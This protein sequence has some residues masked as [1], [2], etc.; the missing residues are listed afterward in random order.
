MKE[1]RISSTSAIKT[2][3][4]QIF[5]YL[6]EA[7]VKNE[8]AANERIY[9]KENLINEGRNLSWYQ[10]EIILDLLEAKLIK[11]V[12]LLAPKIIQHYTLTDE[13]VVIA[14]KLEKEKL[15]K[16]ENKKTEPSLDIIPAI[17]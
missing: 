1:N 16:E 15:E 2:L 6:K 12:D 4:D 17:S 3:K 14:E 11:E 7:I 5:A 8:I 13:G 9:E 10:W